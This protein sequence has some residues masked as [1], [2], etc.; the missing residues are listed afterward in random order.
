M[1]MNSDNSPHTQTFVNRDYLQMRIPLKR[2]STQVGLHF[3]ELIDY[4]NAQFGQKVLDAKIPSYFTRRKGKVS[5]IRGF[6]Y[7]LFLV[8]K[9]EFHTEFSSDCT[10][11]TAYQP[12][13]TFQSRWTI[14]HFKNQ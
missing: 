14:C 10:Y 9:I 2:S 1:F 5:L 12:L 7:I 3:F 4:Q 6:V 11:R 13:R 8:I